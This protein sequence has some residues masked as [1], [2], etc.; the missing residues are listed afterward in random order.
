[1]ERHGFRGRR[2]LHYDF[3]AQLRGIINGG[4][5]IEA[6]TG[7]D[8]RTV[9]RVV[10]S[11]ALLDNTQFHIAAALLHNFLSVNGAGEQDIVVLNGLPRHV[12]QAHDCEAMV[13][14]LLVLVLDCTA[15]VV[16]ERIL[17]NS[18]GDRSNRTDDS[19]REVS[20]KLLIYREHTEPLIDFYVRKQVPCLRLT[21]VPES[22]PEDHMA[23]LLN[24]VELLHV[25]SSK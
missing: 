2:C 4:S 21:V 6:L 7:E 17:L 14:I 19:E 15:E 22:K 20:R 13:R 16:R 24:R 1:M 18:G 10:S 9:V 8:I 5:D 3:G 11:N 23:A 12:N 25:R